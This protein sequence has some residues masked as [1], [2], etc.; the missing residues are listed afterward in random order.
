[1]GEHWTILFRHGVLRL[2]LSPEVFWRL[3]WREWRMLNASAPAPV[4]DRKNFNDLMQQF[5]DTP[6]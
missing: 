2:G 3:S 1:M 5:P 6:S 4:I